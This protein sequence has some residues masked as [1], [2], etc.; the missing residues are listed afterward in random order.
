M[1]TVW[2]GLLVG[3]LALAVAGIGWLAPVARGELA[4]GG[5]NPDEWIRSL[6]LSSPVMDGAGVLGPERKA[7]LEKAI[8]AGTASNGAQLVVAAL[9]SL[10]GG[11][12][13]DFANRLF[14]QWRIG[15]K[16]KDNGVLLLLALEERQVGIEVGYGFEGALP[17][18][19]C[20]RI[21]DEVILPRFREGDYAAA[22][23]EGA[24]A[25]L[26]AMAGESFGERAGD[27]DKTAVRIFWAVFAGV[28][29]GI[30]W[31][32]TKRGRRSGAG[33]ATPHAARSR[34]P[35]M[36]RHGRMGSAN[37]GGMRRGGGFHGKGGRSGGGGARGGV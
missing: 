35:G 26:E 19:R 32:A 23:E 22:M 14:A 24:A 10:R 8:R 5:K 31:S 11:E 17:D 30:V 2:N 15:E 34:I 4:D 20:G 25:L 6:V 16:G 33:P 36:A 1:K 21:R 7:A 28:V 27:G 37:R 9:P 29:V 3:W 12:I 13:G 18:A